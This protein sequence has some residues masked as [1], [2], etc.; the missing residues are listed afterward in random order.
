[1]FINW[2]NYYFK[3]DL[4]FQCNYPQHYNDILH[5]KRKKDCKLHVGKK[6]PQIAKAILNK[7]SYAVS[8]TIPAFKLI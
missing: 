7:N 3:T 1:M 5:R 4:Q 6:R 8:I 2:E